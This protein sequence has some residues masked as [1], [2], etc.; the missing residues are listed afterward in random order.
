M[1]SRT[2]FLVLAVVALALGSLAAEEPAQE[3][4][5]PA[6]MEAEVAKEI[7]NPC[8][9]CGSNLLSGAFCGGAMKA[10]NEIRT[11]ASQGMTESQ[12][13]ADFVERYG[14]EV[15][16]KPEEKG[17]N[18]VVYWLPGVV[19]LLG[20]VVVG[21]FVRRAIKRGKEPVPVAASAPASVAHSDG[22]VDE[23]EERLRRELESLE[24]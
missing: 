24:G 1:R 3:T 18:L 16:A 13:I 4:L 17:F 5:D 10:K 15:L 7:M 12:I 20:V 8:E 21:L 22:V 6:Q 23:Y 19:L 9:N 2:P 11:M 14:E